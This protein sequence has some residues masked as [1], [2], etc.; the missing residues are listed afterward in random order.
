VQPYSSYFYERFPGWE[1]VPVAQI[2]QFHWEGTRPYRPE[3]YAALCGVRDAGLMARLWSF[4]EP[5]NLRCEGTERDDPIWQDSCLE[6]FFQPVPGREEYINIEMNP[7][8]VYLSQFGPRRKDR[9]FIKEL[10]DFAPEVLPF[11]PETSGWGVEVTLPEALIAALYGTE[12]RIGPGSF[13]GNCYKCGDKTPRPHYGA[14]FPVGN[15][16]L[17]FHNPGKF[18]DIILA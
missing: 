14:L 3:S 12:Y 8:G 17:G 16:L 7:K 6:L 4:E 10:T 5:E 2:A 18:G 15:P 11:M 13:R 1:A 9:V